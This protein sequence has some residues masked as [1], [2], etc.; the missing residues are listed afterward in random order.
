M[1]AAA[2]AVLALLVVTGSSSAQI[3]NLP[4][5]GPDWTDIS[6]P[7]IY[8]STR[9]GWA[10]GLYYAQIKQLKFDDWDAPPPYA[11]KLGL[12]FYFGT[13]GSK[14]INLEARMPKLVDGWRFTARLEYRRRARENYFGVGNASVY[15]RDVLDTLPLFYRSDNERLTGRGEMQRRIVGP[16]RLLAG[17][18]AERWRIDTLVEPGPSQ[19]K[20]DVLS[21]VDP[22]IGN[23]VWDVWGFAG[24]VL[25]TRDDEVAARSGVKLEAIVGYADS[26]IAGDLSYVRYTGSAA[27]YLSV[28]EKLLTTVRL[29]GQSITGSPR[30][31]SYYLLEAPERP[32]MTYGGSETHRGLRRRRLLDADK[33]FGNLDVRYDLLAEPSLYRLTLVGFLDVGRVFPSGQFE[34]TTDD[35][36]WGGGFG[37]VAQIFRAGI[38]GG[39]IGWGLDGASAHFHMQWPY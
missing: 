33:I 12:D 21:G 9:D 5:L 2:G 16:L 30:L 29:V 31:G 14:R 7:K 10:F 36:H 17:I 3:P 11:A 8:Y 20:N 23:W 28:T 25:D 39:T 22:T 13:T 15:N 26:S 34:F 6:Y 1:R 37:I 32:Y 19:L 4:T 35:L 18:H 38:L 27:G 24:L